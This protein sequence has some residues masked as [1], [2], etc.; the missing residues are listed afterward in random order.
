M[1][2]TQTRFI[3]CKKTCHFHI[4]VCNYLNKSFSRRYFLGLHFIC[5]LWFWRKFQSFPL[6]Q[7]I[8]NSFDSSACSEME[9]TF[10]WIITS[11][12]SCRKCK[13]FL[14]RTSA[15]EIESFA[16]ISFHHIRKNQKKIF[17]FFS[18]NDYLLLQIVRS[19]IRL[20]LVHFV[21][22]WSLRRRI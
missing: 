21:F 13:V 11:S 22:V 14:Y 3:C 6:I 19:Q 8:T 20:L 12:H 9:Y 1:R 18:P 2:W 15:H 16:K 17:S 10:K 4:A 5:H 7:E